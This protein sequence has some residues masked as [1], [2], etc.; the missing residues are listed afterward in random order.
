M[1]L[2]HKLHYYEESQC[3][4]FKFTT[5]LY[6]VGGSPYEILCSSCLYV[7]RNKESFQI[8]SDTTNICLCLC[9]TVATCLEVT[10][11]H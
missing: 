6:P 2:S 10:S 4:L 9:L 5:G 1:L 3:V 11:G 8:P 7:D